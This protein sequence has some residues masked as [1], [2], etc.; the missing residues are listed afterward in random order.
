MGVVDDA[1]ER[2]VS[3]YMLSKAIGTLPIACVH[4]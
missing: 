3:L 4:M 2:S 1:E